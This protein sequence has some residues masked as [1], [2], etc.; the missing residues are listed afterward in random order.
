MGAHSLASNS[1]L[2]SQPP[3]ST[4]WGTGDGQGS[5][6]SAYF[7]RQLCSLTLDLLHYP[8]RRHPLTG[9][10]YVHGHT[11][12]LSSMHCAHRD[13]L[14]PGATTQ[15]APF[16]P[17]WRHFHLED[18]MTIGTSL[19]STSPTHRTHLTQQMSLLPGRLL[20]NRHVL[21]QQVPNFYSADTTFTENTFTQQG[22]H[23]ACRHQL[24]PAYT[25][26]I[27]THSQV[28]A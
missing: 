25:P 12:L 1:S 21:T 6:V 2:Y 23:H 9:I 5:I 17:S 3:G 22:L 26:P 14:H 8:T 24:Y 7:L 28:R 18:R 19:P 16:L 11:D 15:Q 13:H 4:M 20:T 27:S 10:N